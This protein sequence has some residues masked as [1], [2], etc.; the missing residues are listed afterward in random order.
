MPDAPLGSVLRLTRA[1]M[2][3]SRDYTYRG[4]PVIDER[5]FIC[6]ARVIAVVTEP[7]RIK[8]KT[9]QRQ[10]RVKTVKSKMRYTV[11]R[12]TELR[13]MADGLEEDSS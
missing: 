2:L 4:D 13:V 1:S 3:G 6:R 12:I 8:E 9:K 10:R 7:M 11:L 5:H